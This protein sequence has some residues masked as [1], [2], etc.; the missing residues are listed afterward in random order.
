MFPED[1][2]RCFFATSFEV[3][4]F[5][6]QQFGSG[7]QATYRSQPTV[8]TFWHPVCIQVLALLS[9][10]RRPSVLKQILLDDDSLSRAY[11]NWQQS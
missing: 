7:K 8:Q 9:A 10:A 4:K 6:H 3:E 1:N 11:R 5:A 2:S